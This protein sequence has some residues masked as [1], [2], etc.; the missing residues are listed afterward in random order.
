MRVPSRR[1]S[2]L[3]GGLS[4]GLVFLARE[5]TPATSSAEKE[6]P[7]VKVRAGAGE[8]LAAVTV[9]DDGDVAS[10]A[11]YMV[12]QV[13]LPVASLPVAE[14]HGATILRP[15]GPA[16]FAV[17]SVPG[18]SSAEDFVAQLQA[19]G[20]WDAAP[21][22][23]MR[24]AGKGGTKGKTKD[25]ETTAAETSAETTAP[26]TT[27]SDTTASDTTASETTASETTTAK[28]TAADTTADTTTAST[29]ST[30]SLVKTSITDSAQCERF[31]PATPIEPAQWH[32]EAIN[33]QANG[34]KD[35]SAITVAVL[36]SGVA[37]HTD[38]GLQAAA[39]LSTSSFV[40]PYDFVNLDAVPSDDHMHGTHI[41]SLIAS[42]GDVEGIAPGVTLM[43]VKVLDENNEGTEVALLDGLAWAV[44][45]GA[46]IINLSLSFDPE[47]RPSKALI[48]ALKSANDAG[49][50]VVA[51]A[52][53]DGLRTVTWPAAH[54]MVI[55]VGA[56]G[57]STSYA[58][59][60][61]ITDYSNR[62]TALDI[63]APGGDLS[64][65]NNEDGYPDGM[66][67]ESIYPQDPSQ[68]GLWFM[69]GS[70]QATAVISGVAAV[71]LASGGQPEDMR[72][73]LQDFT[74]ISG[75]VAAG[76]SSGVVDVEEAVF[77]ACSS[78]FTSIGPYHLAMLP[79][80]KVASGMVQASFVLQL[81]DASGISVE[82]LEVLAT[83]SGASAGSYSCVTDM[84]G[85]CTITPDA[86]SEGKDGLA[87]ALS[88]D[89]VVDKW[90]P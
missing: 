57:Y 39:S 51:A 64:V 43:P 8:L 1:T 11:V 75:D 18:E 62:S 3:L 48:Q 53:N 66:L 36:D 71:V 20:I 34:S 47:Y 44:A 10:S 68:T 56:T 15:A 9:A 49:V 50:V 63:L 22:G 78:S 87:W 12:G 70:S 29:D 82:N 76:E 35:L 33:A 16:G 88:V 72:L 81:E 79:K 58:A 54:P 24:G 13:M 28:S 25:S 26:D 14:A 27:A 46:D 7:V 74:W 59:S 55:S 45:E 61:W 21:V 41:A 73:I 84:Y 31:E 17:V 60:D 52:G 30:D 38:A 69:A 6:A 89:T 65:D 85:S 37:Y 32:L 5:V 4:I 42:D 23:V 83:L 77:A 40:S 86:A 90:G 67:A 2:L 19:D 80:A